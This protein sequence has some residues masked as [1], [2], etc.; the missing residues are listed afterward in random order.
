MEN[1]KITLQQVTIKQWKDVIEQVK[2]ATK[3]G[4][5]GIDLDYSDITE[6]IKKGNSLNELKNTLNKYNMVISHI[7]SFSGWQFKGGLPMVSDPSNK[8][9]KSEDEMLQ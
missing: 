5:C 2:I 1:P 3:A 9:N 8:I 4:Y 6:Y 7:A